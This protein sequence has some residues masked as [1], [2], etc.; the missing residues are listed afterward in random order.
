MVNRMHKR[1]RVICAGM[2]IVLL[3]LVLLPL[4]GWMELGVQAGRKAEEV[5]E[6]LLNIHNQIALEKAQEG[7]PVGDPIEMEEAWEIEDTREESFEPLVTAML[8][9]SDVLGFDAAENTFYCTIGMETEDEWPEISLKARNVPDG[10]EIR[11]VDDYA[12]DWCSDAIR[13]GYR[14]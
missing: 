13:E 4:S 6:P 9:G 3:V 5:Y 11:L 7:I 10:L 2:M 12:Y 1:S 8:N 14:Y